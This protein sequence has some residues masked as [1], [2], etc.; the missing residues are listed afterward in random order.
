MPA[1][2]DRDKERCRYHLG[3]LGQG[4]SAASIQMGIPQPLQTSFLVESAMNLLASTEVV[5]RVVCILDTMDK[6]EAQ[7]TSAVATLTVD[8]VDNLQLHPLRS[9]GKLSTDCIEQELTRW[10]YRLSDVLGAP[11]YPYARRYMKRGPGS[12]LPVA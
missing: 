12:V 8:R 11:V 3:Y 4:P 5:A 2:T 1:L 7:L 9:M 6:L 10:G